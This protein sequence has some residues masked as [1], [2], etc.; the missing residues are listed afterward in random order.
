MTNS[1]DF[2]RCGN[3]IY[4]PPTS[5]WLE[6]WTR[7]RWLEKYFKEP[8]RILVVSDETWLFLQEQHKIKTLTQTNNQFEECKKPIDERGRLGSLDS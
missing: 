8:E 1:Q 5:S 7:Q 2:I 6:G 3:N 4:V